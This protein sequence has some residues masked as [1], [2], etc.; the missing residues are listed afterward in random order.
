MDLAN[1]S[2]SF[3]SAV[4]GE[5]VLECHKLCYDEQEGQV[6]DEC[7][8]NCGYKQAQLINIFNRTLQKEMPRL[9]ELS[10]L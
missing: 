2:K 7:V 4:A 10:R 3:G 6:N 8:K 9:Q 5:V 1:L